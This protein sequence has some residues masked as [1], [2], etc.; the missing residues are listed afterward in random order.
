MRLL[1]FNLAT[2]SEDPVLG[3]T[4]HWIRALARQVESIRVITM[5]VGRVEVPHNVRV[6][7]LGKERGYSE[8]RRAMEFYRLLFRIFS[9]SPI[10]ACFSHMNPIFTILAAPM[11]KAKR[12]PIV[13][14]YA[15]PNVTWILKLAH[16]FSNQMVASIATA[17][18]YT[19]EKLK[20]VGQG[21]D[22]DLFSADSRSSTEDSAMILCAGRLS[23]VKGHATLLRAASLL[24]RHWGKPF[25]VVILGG[26]A[27]PDDDSYVSFLHEKVRELNLE[28]T[29]FFEAA[30]PMLRLPSWYRQCTVHV[31]MTPTGF[32]DKVA[33]EAMSCGKPCVVANDGFRETLGTY[34]DRLLFRYGDAD[35]LANR[36]LGLLEVSETER[37]RIGLY[38]RQQVIEMHSIDRLAAKLVELFQAVTK[39]VPRGLPN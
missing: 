38:L 16:Y 24:Q 9:E 32:G 31:N 18:P 13:T 26:P 12:I 1:L 15:H 23:P 29:V 20:V 22:T 36:L 34:A 30:V 25:R 5:R 21:I 11:L 28:N 33:W 17:Y 39:R 10:D 35:D 19:K 6:Y 27:T 4:T 2:D 14:W 3:F 8:P 7:S 37:G